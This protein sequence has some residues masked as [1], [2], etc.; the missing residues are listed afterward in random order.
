MPILEL[1]SVSKEFPLAGDQRVYAVDEVS[2]VVEAGTTVALIG[3]SG[4]GKSTLGRLAIRLLEPTSGSVRFDGR[5]LA[6]LSR[7]E[8]RALRSNLQIIFQEPFE[9]LDPRMT[10]GRII[11]EP[12][13]IHNPELGIG[14]RRQRVNETLELVGL[15]ATMYS[16]YP[17]ELS[18]GQQQRV[19]IARAIITQPRLVVLDEPTSSLDLS[20]RAQILQL[21]QRLQSEMQMAYL[22]ISHDIHTVRYMSDWIAVMYHGRVVE[23]GSAEKIFAEPFHPYTKALLASALSVQPGSEMEPLAL[24][25]D[26]TPPVHKPTACV[27]LKRCPYRTA[28][29]SEGDVPLVDVEQGRSVACINVDAVRGLS[30]SGASAPV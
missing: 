5:D 1:E 12:L 24:V 18:G 14:Q 29:C 3:E 6:D 7:A 2:L 15:P 20:V 27:L 25:G 11:G 19:G 22:F 28:E 23:S 26:P 21:L 4:S 30:A 9:S 17:G 13:S 10:V 8:L 16:R